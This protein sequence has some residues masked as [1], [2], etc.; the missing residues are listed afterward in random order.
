M[1][2]RLVDQIRF[3]GFLKRLQEY[4]LKMAGKLSVSIETDYDY[5]DK[6]LDK[7]SVEIEY[8]SFTFYSTDR[9]GE[10][11]SKWDIMEREV[12]ALLL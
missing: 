6:S 5:K 4:Q 1:A 11:R 2:K 10:L 3:L 8:L 12:K 9:A 7:I